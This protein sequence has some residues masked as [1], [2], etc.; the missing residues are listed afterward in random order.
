M[1]NEN[2][3]ND[4]VR[5]PGPETIRQLSI[6]KLMMGDD[7]AN[8]ASDEKDEKEYVL[9]KKFSRELPNYDSVSTVETDRHS[10]VSKRSKSTMPMTIEEESI[11]F[12]APDEGT[13]AA[14][15]L[16]ANAKLNV[17]IYTKGLRKIPIMN[18]L[19]LS[20]AISRRF[21]TKKKK[22]KRHFSRNFKGKVI[23]GV[24][25][26]YTLT[27]G[28][29]LGM[30]CSVGHR[31]QAATAHLSLDDFTYAEKIEFPPDGCTTG[32]HHTPPHKL[33]HTFKMKTYA[34]MVFRRLRDFFGIDPESYMSSVCGDYNY[35]EFI[36]N[37][38]S[39][40]FFFYSHDGRY[41]IKTQTSE[42]TKFL[43]RILPHYYKYVTENPDTLL[44]RFLG[45]HRVKMYHLKRKVHFVIMTSVFD[46]PEEINVIYDLKGSLIGRK[47]TEAERKKGGVLKDLDLMEDG[48]KIQLGSKRETFLKQ[49]RRDANFLA[50]HNIMDYSLLIG[51][52]DRNL[53][54]PAHD[55]TPRSSAEHTTPPRVHSARSEEVHKSPSKDLKARHRSPSSTPPPTRA[56]PPALSTTPRAKS[57]S[58]VKGTSFFSHTT[59]SNASHS[60]TPFRRI[61]SI[62]APITAPTPS[63]D[64]EKEKDQKASI[65]RHS[66]SWDVDKKHTN[67]S[68][69]AVDMGIQNQPD[70][71]IDM[72]VTVQVDE[73]TGTV[74]IDDKT[75]SEVMI[76]NNKM[77]PKLKSKSV[78]LYDIHVGG[79]SG[80]MED[81]EEEE[82]EE[83]S[84]DEHYDDGDSILDDTDEKQ[85]ISSA[86]QSEKTKREGGEK[87]TKDELYTAL[88][89]ALH[90][91]GAKVGR[92]FREGSGVERLARRSSEISACP[93]TFGRNNCH[94]H[95]WTSRHDGGIN[96]RDEDGR[97][98][99][100]YFAGIIDVLQQYS[101]NKRV[102][103]FVKGFKYKRD[104]ISAVDSYAYAKRFIE[105]MEAH[106]T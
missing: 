12:H 10:Y 89:Q 90:D 22:R 79:V 102:E 49:I 40:Q 88:D 19:N 77:S 85:D 74:I 64:S 91:E 43:N 28:M 61:G 94:S 75:K 93:V 103:N 27:A 68:G 54:R 65:F 24:H 53:R 41:M 16:E 57:V 3:Q 71:K 45:I 83:F 86:N 25:E 37:S 51:M 96:G 58:L 59:H 13:P 35:L 97:T 17:S 87:F 98:N 18:K 15:A 33:A 48:T 21:K 99:M 106:V 78:D 50:Q 7:E 101:A 46:T 80:S 6:Q 32:P 44:V 14:L 67:S 20:K 29:M 60:N 76:S 36:S 92:L 2:A 73:I 105:F 5:P 9:Q 95:P 26:L 38:K 52:H 1:P 30:R 100:I 8:Q 62:S 55:T 69:S 11:Q 23:D 56:I 4:D 47:A 72:S 63:A 34:P 39:G 82:E 104:Q 84:E 70:K 42:E 31:Q 66:V 81:E